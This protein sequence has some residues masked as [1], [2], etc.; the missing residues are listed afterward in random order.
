MPKRSQP[1]A[2][3]GGG[4]GFDGDMV[5][6]APNP[7]RARWHLHSRRLEP[8]NQVVK[9]I[10]RG[11]VLPSRAACPVRYRGGSRRRTPSLLSLRPS[12]PCPSTRLRL[13]PSPKPRKAFTT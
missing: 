1:Q 8:A 13:R 9:L 10:K 6:A 11:I 4:G 7:D 5:G 3:S 2:A 12:A